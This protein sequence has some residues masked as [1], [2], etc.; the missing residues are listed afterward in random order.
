MVFTGA[1][2]CKIT[3]YCGFTNP[4]FLIEDNSTHGLIPVGRLKSMAV[5]I[6]RQ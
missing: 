4:A 2:C 5:I 6:K 3:R 1:D